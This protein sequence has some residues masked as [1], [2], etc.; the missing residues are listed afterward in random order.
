EPP[1]GRPRPIRPDR[2]I[3]RNEPQGSK[4][5][6]HPRP[7]GKQ[8]GLCRAGSG[9]VS[10]CCCPSFLASAGRQANCSAKLI[11]IAALMLAHGL[12]AGAPAC[13][14]PRTTPK[15]NRKEDTSNGRFYVLDSQRF[16][17]TGRA[18]PDP[19]NGGPP[20]KFR[21]ASFLGHERG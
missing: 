14:R 2:R 8:L 16:Q 17:D 11:S 1:T 9:G 5:H 6:R 21:A 7:V 20:C 4:P 13:Q 15:L 18:P 10:P 19:V 3:G 12:F